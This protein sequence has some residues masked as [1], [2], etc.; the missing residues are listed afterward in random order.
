MLIYLHLFTKIFLLV[1]KKI[2]RKNHN[3]PSFAEPFVEAVPQTLILLSIS[4]LSGVPRKEGNEII[5]DNCEPENCGIASLYFEGMKPK[6]WL[7]LTTFE[8]NKK[9]TNNIKSRP[10]SRTRTTKWWWFALSFSTIVQKK[11]CYF[12]CDK[13][14]L[15]RSAAAK[16]IH[17]SWEFSGLSN[18]IVLGTRTLFRNTKKLNFQ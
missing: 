8:A 13:N 5:F 9:K 14:D 3:L 16:Y 6:D 7:F 11:Q 4:Y 1:T 2:I 10:A 18:L 12:E 15:V 17:A